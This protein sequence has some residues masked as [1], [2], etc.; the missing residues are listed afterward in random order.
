MQK[1]GVHCGQVLDFLALM[2]DKVDGIPGLKGCG[3]KT[4]AKWLTQYGNLQGIYDNLDKIEGKI[5]QTL[6]DNIE[7]V[8]ISRKL[9]LLHSSVKCGITWGDLRR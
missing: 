1:F 3:P 8:K 6:R 2:G 5:G 7:D 4:A 9:T